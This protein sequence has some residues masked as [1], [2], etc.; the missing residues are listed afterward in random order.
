MG[1]Y[2]HLLLRRW[3]LIVAAVAVVLHAHGDLHVQAAQKQ[4]LVPCMYIF[5][6]SLVDNGNNNNILSLARANYRPYGVDFPDGAAPPGRFTNGRT[7]VDLLADH[8]G[9]Q[10]PF[11]PAYAMAQPSDY[12]RG[13]NFASGAAGVRPETGN[14]LGGHYP[15]SEQVSHFR[16]VVGQI[17][18]AGRDKRLGRCIYYVGMGSN[19]YLNNY[20]MPDYY[21]T[22]QAY[23]PAAYAAALLQEYERQLT[24]LYALGARKFVVAGVG[25]I[26]CIPYE[27]ARIDDDADDQG[28]G[29][30]PPTSGIG[31]TIPGG[32]TVGIGGSGGNRSAANG[33]TKSRSGCN[34]KINSAIAIYN[35]GLLAMVKRLNR[36]QQTPGANLVF[37][38]AVNS[39][40]DLAANAAA[41]GFTVLDRGCCGVG[42][43][44]GQITCLPM[45]RP[46]DD[47]TKYIFWDAFHP[48]EAANRIIA[49]KVFSSSSTTDAYP[50]NVSRLAAI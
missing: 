26:G 36:G 35:K 25:Q 33:S 47:R 41:Y 8:L 18:P 42:R 48:T 7:M 2:H 45:Q 31:L 15:L 16:S 30:P 24:A 39:G 34:D 43:N 21:N 12:A 38:N 23:D 22:A 6:D 28:R 3:V 32:I 19:D 17:A 20:F 40:K 9:F 13:L 5:G 29:R 4:Q 37:L 1:N 50:I 14:N 10:P 49:N 44:N 11:I 27:L 46:C